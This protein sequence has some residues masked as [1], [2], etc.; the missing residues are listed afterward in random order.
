MLLHTAVV[1]V[2][3]AAMET[4]A[5]AVANYRLGPLLALVAF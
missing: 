5:V 1:V 3:K 2:D 4:A